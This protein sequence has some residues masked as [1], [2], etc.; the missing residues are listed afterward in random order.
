MDGTAM[1]IPRPSHFGGGGAFLRDVHHH[2]EVRMATPS[3]LAAV[4]R[5]LEALWQKR[6]PTAAEEHRM[7]ELKREYKFVLVSDCGRRYVRWR[8]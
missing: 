8:G 7:Q 5:E 2:K 1:G 6:Y 3:W 4:H